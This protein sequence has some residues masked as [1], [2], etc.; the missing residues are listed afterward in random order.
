MAIISLCQIHSTR[1]YI[2]RIETE[3]TYGVGKGKM[4]VE[5]VGVEVWD[6]A[7]SVAQA[8][9][10]CIGLGLEYTVVDE[11]EVLPRTKL[12]FETGIGEVDDV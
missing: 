11:V 5:W 10:Y 3:I 6:K 9:S 8:V 2:S 7:E 1:K 12:I 4:S